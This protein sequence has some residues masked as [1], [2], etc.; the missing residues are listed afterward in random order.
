ME[1]DCFPAQGLHLELKSPVSGKSK[2]SGPPFFGGNW[3]S[4]H[5]GIFLLN[6][7]FRNEFTPHQKHGSTKS[8]AEEKKNE[9][10]LK[11]RGYATAAVQGHCCLKTV[12]GDIFFSKITKSIQSYH[13]HLIQT[14]DPCLQARHSGFPFGRKCLTTESL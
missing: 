4:S 9:T 3:W 13:F 11:K 6:F 1:P 5:T 14:P 2:P 10:I 8:T 12:F 7:C